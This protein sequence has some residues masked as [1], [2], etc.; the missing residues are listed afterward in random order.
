MISLDINPPLLLARN[1]LFVLDCLDD[2]RDSRTS[3]AEEQDSSG[4]DGDRF[5][6][7]AAFKMET[8][9]LPEPGPPVTRR[10][11]WAAMIFS[12]FSVSCIRTR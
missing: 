9:V 5:A 11:P 7:C 1:L 3:K 2:A 12:C 10:C 6:I 8:V 4:L